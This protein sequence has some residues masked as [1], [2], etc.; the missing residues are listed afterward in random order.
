MAVKMSEFHGI[1]PTHLAKLREAKIEDTD[2]L[3]KIWSDKTKRPG[4]IESTG[5][6]EEHFLKFA[7]MARLSRVKGM[8]LKHLNVLVAADIDGPKRLFSY[9]P[10]TLAKHLAAVVAEKKLTDP[11]PTHEDLVI[12]YADPKRAPEPAAAK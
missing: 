3:M 11:V 10:E 9:T 4:L 2:E 8:D 5:I 1:D 6:A 7:G 12:W